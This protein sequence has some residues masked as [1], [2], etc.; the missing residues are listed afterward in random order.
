M[1][2]LISILDLTPIAAGSSSAQAVRDSVELAVLAERLGALERDVS[3][4]RRRV[5]VAL[6]ALSAELTRRY[7]DGEASIDGLLQPGGS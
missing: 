2:R 4:R 3:A 6:D 5:Y 1:I 7:R